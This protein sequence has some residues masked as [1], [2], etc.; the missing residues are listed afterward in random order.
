MGLVQGNF[1]SPMDYQL[2]PQCYPYF[3]FFTSLFFLFIYFYNFFILMPL[4]LLFLFSQ[5]L[6][7]GLSINR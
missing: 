4:L 3:L 6:S 7:I 1:I 5:Y 2:P